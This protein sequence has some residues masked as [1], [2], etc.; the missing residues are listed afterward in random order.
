MVNTSNRALK[1]TSKSQSKSDD[2][3]LIW[4]RTITD[5]TADRSLEAFAD[6]GCN[7]LHIPCIE[8]EG[9]AITG[10][11]QPADYVAFTSANAVSFSLNHAELGKIIRS[12]TAVY[13]HGV[14]TATALAHHGIQVSLVP[15]RTA[16][17]LAQWLVRHLPKSASI[18]LP[19]ANEP[20]W[21]MVET[22]CNHGLQARGYSV[23]QTK[24]L[25][26]THDGKT[27]TP[28][29]AKLVQTS[30]RGII[31][32]ASPSAVR[33][34][35]EVFNPKEGSIAKELIAVAIGPT[36]RDAAAKYFERVEMAEDNAIA[37]LAATARQLYLGLP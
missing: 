35:C 32:F 6:Q 10:P 9:V 19:G 16:E 18:C 24:S 7:L 15:V 26:R 20:A 3:V 37:S 1:N 14:A 2:K 31:A 36:T 30:W 13:T 4:T 17:E 22:L 11:V 8:I 34:F 21:P 23:Y 25:A 5:W 28:E 12:A 27:W 29:D 33:G